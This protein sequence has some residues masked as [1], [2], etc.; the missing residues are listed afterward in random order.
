MGLSSFY[1]EVISP[2]LRSTTFGEKLDMALVAF[3]ANLQ[4]AGFMYANSGGRIFTDAQ[5]EAIFEGMDEESLSIAKRFI[6][7]QYKCAAN[8]LMI[9]PKYFYTPEEKA[10][11]QQLL[12]EYIRA[13]RRF[14]LPRHKVRPESLYYHHGLRFVPEFVKKNI[15]GKLFADVGGWLGDSTLV[16]ENYAPAKTVIFEPVADCREQ[17][18]KTMKRNR[19]SADRFDLQPYGLSDISGSF[20]GMEC[21]KLDDFDFPVPF[22]VLKADIEGMGLRFLLGAEKTIK[23][24]RPL[25]SL[26][27]YHNEDEFT[28]I[29]RT[30][31]EWDINYHCEIRS[32]APMASHG[33]VSLLAYPE[34]WHNR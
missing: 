25:L 19:I 24:D 8:S 2:F 28:G 17:L 5:I 15:R 23:R 11:Q 32:F 26:S 1:A 33:E 7:R 18:L 22:G 21:R 6:S 20:D 29:Y 14:H 10:E 31:K 4:F 13:L 9:H 27:I 34:E 30:L 3:N 12:P 16:F